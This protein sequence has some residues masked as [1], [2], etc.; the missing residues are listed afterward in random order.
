MSKEL[1][2][3]EELDVKGALAELKKLGKEVDFGDKVF[4]K[5]T[6]LEELQAAVTESRA[7]LADADDEDDDDDDSDKGAKGKIRDV[8]E[9]KGFPIFDANGKLFRTVKDADDAKK[10]ASEIGGRVGKK[11]EEAAEPRVQSKEPA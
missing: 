9:G 7:A 2:P 8:G 1:K 5:E 4:D 11:G 6:P 10:L 3:V